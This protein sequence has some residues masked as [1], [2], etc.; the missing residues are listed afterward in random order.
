MLTLLPF[1][2]ID[3]MTNFACL[4]Y[5]AYDCMF[6]L[7]AFVVVVAFCLFVFFSTSMTYYLFHSHIFYIVDQI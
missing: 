4:N 3:N 1:Y 6:P 7:Y 5:L 2:N